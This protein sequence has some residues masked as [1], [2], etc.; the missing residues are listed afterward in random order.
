MTIIKIEGNNGYHTVESQSHR[1]ENW[2]GD[3]WIEV[4]EELELDLNRGYCDLVIED[5]I[6]ISVTPNK[7]LIDQNT[8][9]NDKISYLS[10]NCNK[11]I[12]NGFDIE[13][14]DTSG[15]V[16]LTAEDQINLSTAY[17]SI[18]QGAAQYPYHL[19][20]QLCQMFSAED[21]SKIA[22]TAT[23]HKLYH[24]TY[25]NH[26]KSWVERCETK[27]EI[28]AIDYGSE[29]PEDLASSMNSIISAVSNL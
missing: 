2:M 10:F 8:Y 1:E 4:P 20:G 16:S 23:A 22:Q 5:G 19:D 3:E 25:F 13:L 9:K 7:I 26:L 28:D 29:L 24:T 14:S 6:L 12:T 21:I 18:L 11:M 17:N 15:H 27:E